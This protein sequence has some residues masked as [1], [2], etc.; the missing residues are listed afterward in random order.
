MI[1][2]PE[3]AF[4]YSLATLWAI[5]AKAVEPWTVSAPIAHMG[6]GVMARLAR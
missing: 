3:Q 4:S 6:S 1:D 5:E 2:A